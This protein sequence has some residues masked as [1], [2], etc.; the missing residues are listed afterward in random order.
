M[1]LSLNNILPILSIIALILDIIGVLFLYKYGILPDNLW[2]HILMDSGMSRADEM[3]HRKMSKVGLRFLISGFGIQLIV[4][5]L[6]Y[7]K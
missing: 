4:T 7:F 5:A 3:K 2:E 1:D 6:Q